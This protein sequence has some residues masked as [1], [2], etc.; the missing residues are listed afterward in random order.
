MSPAEWSRP[1]SRPDDSRLSPSVAAPLK[2][3]TA[4]SDC[5]GCWSS[6]NSCRASSRSSAARRLPVST[7]IVIRAATMPGRRPASTHSAP[8]SRAIATTWLN[9]ANS[10]GSRISSPAQSS[11]TCRTRVCTRRSSRLER[12][13]GRESP[14]KSAGSVATRQPRNRFRVTPERSGPDS[15]RDPRGPGVWGKG[16]GNRPASVVSGPGSR[17]SAIQHRSGETPVR[18]RRAGWRSS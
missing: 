6:S 11:T 9:P 16:I 8:S 17:G 4:S 3:L 7:S 18:G 14:D 10:S 12:R 2:A 5:G 1:A 15:G 13:L